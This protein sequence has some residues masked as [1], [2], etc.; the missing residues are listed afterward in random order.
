[1]GNLRAESSVTSLFSAV[2]SEFTELRDL[3]ELELALHAKLTGNKPAQDKITVNPPIKT[4]HLCLGH[5]SSHVSALSLIMFTA[6]SCG[7]IKSLLS[8]LRN[9]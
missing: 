2:I 1:M 7:V 6:S 4:T 3:R 9:K 5:K 8:H